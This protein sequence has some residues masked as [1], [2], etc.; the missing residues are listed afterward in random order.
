MLSTCTCPAAEPAPA[1][2]IHETT[3]TSETPSATN[4]SSNSSGKRF[5]DSSV[6][7]SSLGLQQIDVAGA[8]SSASIRDDDWARARALFLRAAIKSKERAAAGGDEGSMTMPVSGASSD[9]SQGAGSEAATA[10]GSIAEAF[11]AVPVTEASEILQRNLS[12]ALRGIGRGSE[13]GADLSAVGLSTGGSLD[14][15]RGSLMEV[16]DGSRVDHKAVEGAWGREGDT[17][18]GGKEQEDRVARAIADTCR[19]IALECLLGR[20]GGEEAETLA[21]GRSGDGR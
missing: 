14:D 5:R 9:S 4:I 2:N 13:G 17:E 20:K 18:G 12:R 7:G 3:H 11:A 16:D 10:A 6:A 1:E 21:R 15:A 8:E 19:D